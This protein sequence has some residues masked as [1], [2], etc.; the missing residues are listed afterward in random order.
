MSLGRG[1][2]KTSTVGKWIPKLMRGKFASNLLQMVIFEVFS[3]C[4]YLEKVVQQ[5][6]KGS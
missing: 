5:M 3:V 4:K 2:G 6:E 1:F